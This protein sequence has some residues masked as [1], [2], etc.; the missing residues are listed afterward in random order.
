MKNHKTI[1]EQKQYS[2][3]SNGAKLVAMLVLVALVLSLLALP[4]SPISAISTSVSANSFC[5][6][7]ITPMVSDFSGTAQLKRGGGLR[8]FTTF[9]NMEVRAG[10]TVITGTNSSITITYGE[11]ELVVGSNSR[12]FIADFR[13]QNDTETSSIHIM[14]GSVL[15][16]VKREMNSNCRNTIH[17]SNAI[18]GVRG[19][20]FI[21]SYD[22]KIVVL[23]GEVRFDD[24]DSGYAFSV[25]DRGVGRIMEDFSP[26]TTSEVTTTDAPEFERFQMTLQ[27]I[28][29]KI[30]ENILENSPHLIEANPNF[31]EGVDEILEQKREEAARRELLELEMASQTPTVL[32]V[33]RN[34]DGDD[35]ATN[36]DDNSSINRPST[37]A[38]VT[39]PNTPAF[40]PATPNVTTTLDDAPVATVP[41]PAVTSPIAP[42]STTLAP[43]AITVPPAVTTPA[44]VRTPPPPTPTV[45]ARLSIT[46]EINEIIFSPLLDRG[47]ERFSVMVSGLRNDSD[48]SRLTLQMRGLPANVSWNATRRTP[49]GNRVIF[50]VVMSA[51]SNNEFSNNATIS[52]TGLVD[53][54]TQANAAISLSQTTGERRANPIIVTQRNVERFTAFANT[55]A[56]NGLHYALGESITLSSTQNWTPIGSVVQPFSGSFDGR[57]HSISNMRISPVSE[58]E[59]LQGMFG[60]VGLSGQVANLR[61]NN[62]N[63]SSGGAFAGINHGLITNVST[64][65]NRGGIVGVNTETG[66]ISN[67]YS[68]FSALSL[69][70]NVGGIALENHGVIC[71]SVSVGTIITTAAL[72]GGIAVNNTGI[73]QHSVFIGNINSTGSVG[74]ITAGNSGTLI[75]NFATG[76]NDAPSTYNGTNGRALTSTQYR[77]RTWWETELGFDFASRAFDWDWCDTTNFPTLPIFDVHRRRSLV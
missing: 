68:D 27:G 53:G 65:G 62:T 47:E 74:L 3:H 73:I 38:P 37:T 1:N 13:L 6:N 67:A 17:T 77:N 24:V 2:L 11:N 10:D 34:N 36:N 46:P 42:P 48:V 70:T 4:N 61:L 45:P 43:P 30:L 39:N 64:R 33:P 50:D 12:V 49:S 58:G 31:F 55:L 44:T 59:L 9:R 21:M 16:R 41:P 76:G 66:R 26:N 15:N 69:G 25:S 52:L 57:G 32:F 35:D 14:E 19:T 20:E 71:S 63:F 51:T 75:N 40:P 29:L 72:A 60:V 54:Y 22:S 23:E 8:A 18:A 5:A 56:G 28:D 7:E